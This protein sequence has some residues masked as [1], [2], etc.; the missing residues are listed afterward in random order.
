[1]FTGQ[2]AQEILEVM[3]EA[4]LDMAQFH[5]AQTPGDAARVGPGRVI[6]AVWPERH[7]DPVSLERW[8]APWREAS[9]MFL[10]DSGREGGGHGRAIP[11]GLRFLETAGKPSLLAGG[12][13]PASL[14]GIMEGARPRWL[15][16]FDVNSGVE[17]SPGV[18]DRRLMDR[19][20]RAVKGRRASW[21]GSGSP[22]PGRGGG[23][24]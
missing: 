11:G 9:A 19:A 20:A 3:G 2:G 8:L 7:P 10:F 15:S 4:R 12:L 22:A 16:G 6:R 13:G 5:G 14:A 23:G 18:K 24:L 1:V 17:L 21:P